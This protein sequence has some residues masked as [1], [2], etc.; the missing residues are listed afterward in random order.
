VADWR[1]ARIGGEP[2][3]GRA[4]YRKVEKPMRKSLLCTLCLIWVPATELLAQQPAETTFVRPYESDERVEPVRTRTPLPNQLVYE[5]AV[6]RAQ[7]RVARLEARKWLGVSTS[8]PLVQ[9]HTDRTAYP[10]FG[11]PNFATSPQ[12]RVHM[13]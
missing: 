6:F 9:D 4:D 5:R 2:A 8:R 7:Q 12:V 1:S 13:R 3:E 10:R 11:Y